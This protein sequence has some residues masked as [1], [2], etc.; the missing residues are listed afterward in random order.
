[1]KKSFGALTLACIL[2]FS[3][4]TASVYAQTTS[5]TKSSA[6]VSP[7]ATAANNQSTHSG[8]EPFRIDDNGRNDKLK[9]DM[10]KLVTKARAGKLYTS[11]SSQFQPPHSNNLSKTAKI[12]I[13]AG[14]AVVVIGLIVL[15]GIRNINCESR[16]VL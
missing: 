3:L 1:M 11:P 6:P 13:I 14:I 4:T 16:C 8:F 9:A 12:A 10:T 7:D 5:V 15:H 2:I